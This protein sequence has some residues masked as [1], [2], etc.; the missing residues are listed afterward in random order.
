MAA[1]FAIPLLLVLMR[2]AAAQP[3]D[4]LPPDQRAYSEAGKLT[5]PEQE[6][7]ALQ[8]LREDFPG[9]IFGR[10]AGPSILSTLI[11]KLPEQTE[12]IRKFASQLYRETPERERGSMAN[13]IAATLLARG[14][15]LDDA[16]TYAQ[17]AIDSQS[18]S[19]YIR[20]QQDAYRERN[21]PAPWTKDLEK[22]FQT[23]H[24]PR[25]AT[26]GRIEFNLGHDARAR[27]LLEEA[28]LYDKSPI[29]ESA[30][31]QL[32]LKSGDDEKALDYLIAAALSGAAPKE[33]SAML[34]DLFRKQHG[35]SIEGFDAMLD[36]E[37]RKRFPNPLNEAAYTPSSNRSSRV[38]LAE[39]F[40][41]SGCV[42]CVAADLAVDTVLLRYARKDL[43]VVMYHEHI[44]RPDPMTNEDTVAR[45]KSYVVQGVPA[46]VI[47]GKRIPGG[48]GDREQTHAVYNRFNPDIELELGTPPEASLTAGAALTGNIVRVLA[49][50]GAVKGEASDL[51]VHI[52]LLEKQ[53]RYTGEN[54]IRFHPM[55]VRA[56][57]GRDGA[58][59][60]LEKPGSVF[61]QTFDLQQISQAIGKYLDAY[62]AGGH[63]AGPFTFTEKKDRIDPSDVAVVVFVQQEK[64]RHVLQSVYI[65]VNNLR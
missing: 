22:R 33:A 7:A 1:R 46:F 15:M 64:S 35:G 53:L 8:K 21:E 4:G 18:L 56:M 29:I 24:A 63:R 49:A 51:K 11:Q 37:Y 23:A 55:V 6:I 36:A 28:Y 25:L 34:A 38:V 19:A 58:G 48:G 12:R 52:L 40:T 45:G 62:E 9:S 13:Q 14:L 44:P 16:R 2:S 31:G 5:D 17:M 27:R 42:P 30:L 32:A 61:E 59:L 26:L 41:G 43:A 3:T 10:L 50:V 65:D 57:G 54:G 60:P 20:E 47:D 39:V